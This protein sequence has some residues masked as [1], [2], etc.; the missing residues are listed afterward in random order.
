MSFYFI[1]ETLATSMHGND[2]QWMVLHVVT[3][4]LLQIPQLKYARALHESSMS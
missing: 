4:V 3:M 1:L 2:E